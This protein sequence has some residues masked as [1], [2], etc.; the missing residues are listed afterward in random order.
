MSKQI[1]VRLPDQLVDQ[2]DALI[3]EGAVAS[4]ASLVER[5]LEREFRRRLYERE[6]QVLTAL[7]ESGE[8]DEFEELARWGSRQPIDLD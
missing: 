8:P 7:Q 3:A 1:A 4:R 2:I 6:I 5:A